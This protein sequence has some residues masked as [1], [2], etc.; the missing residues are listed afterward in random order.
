MLDAQTFGVCLFVFSFG[1]SYRF[2]SSVLIIL[3]VLVIFLDAMTKYLT[4][5]WRN[6]GFILA[7]NF[8]T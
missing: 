6:E 3:M 4:S 1:Q 2:L 8:R 7:H 5:D